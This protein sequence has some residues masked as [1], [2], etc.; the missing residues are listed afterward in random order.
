MKLGST[1][2]G[3][4]GVCLEFQCGREFLTYNTELNDDVMINQCIVFLTYSVCLLMVGSECVG[5][6]GEGSKFQL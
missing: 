1:S 4:G 6:L 2:A 3:F 5:G